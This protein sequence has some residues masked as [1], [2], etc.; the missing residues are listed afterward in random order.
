MKLPGSVPLSP[1]AL[2][3][4]TSTAPPTCGGVTAVIVVLFTNT[5]LLART[6]P[7][8]T[9]GEA[10]K[11]VPEIVTAVP[12]ESGPVLAVTE[13]TVAPVV[14]AV[15]VVVNDQVDPVAVILAI[16]FDVIFQ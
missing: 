16:V 12:P 14:G 11:F 8:L 1:A 2:V 10:A 13:V 3:T 4:V 9:L 6:Y 15:A 5:I 7:K